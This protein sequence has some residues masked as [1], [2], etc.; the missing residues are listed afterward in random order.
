MEN[1]VIENKVE[2]NYK[3]KVGEHFVRSCKYTGTE[4][5]KI[6]DYNLGSEFNSVSFQTYIVASQIAKL[7]KGTL[8][9]ITTTKIVL[10]NEKE[11]K[12]ND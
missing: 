9:E 7:L 3:I 6:H 11:V 10:R 5:I 4:V 1:K 8:I 12:I 2:V